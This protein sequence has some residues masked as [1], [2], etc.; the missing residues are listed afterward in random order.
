MLS[1]GNVDGAA[2]IFDYGLSSIYVMDEYTYSDRLS[3]T[4]GIDTM[5]MISDDSP[6][7]NADFEATM[8]LP[9]VVL[10]ALVLP[11]SD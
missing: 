4:A 7:R 8:D 1:H 10:M 6:S 3:L 11:T 2:A 9:M 5:N